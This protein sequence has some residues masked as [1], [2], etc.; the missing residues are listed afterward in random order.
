MTNLGRLPYVYIFFG[1]Y[2]T[3]TSSVVI[4]SKSAIAIHFTPVTSVSVEIAI[5]FRVFLSGTAAIAIDYMFL[6]AAANGKRQSYYL[7][8]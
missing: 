1:R 7:S 6:P 4:V 2:K 5:Y 3:I 8:Y